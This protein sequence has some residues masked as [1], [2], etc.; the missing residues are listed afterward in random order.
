MFLSPV[1]LKE[2]YKKME[3]TGHD[4]GTD[5]T[6]VYNLP[7]VELQ[8]VTI[9]LAVW[10]LVLPYKMTNYS[11]SNSGLLQRKFH[12][13]LQSAPQRHSAVTASPWSNKDGVIFQMSCD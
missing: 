6:V 1:F 7:A 12:C 8:A 11:H 4:T 2:V 3:I 5:W 10:G 13:N 9:W